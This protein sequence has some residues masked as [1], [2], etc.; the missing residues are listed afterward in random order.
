M[1]IDNSYLSGSSKLSVVAEWGAIQCSLL[2]KAE[3]I[4]CLMDVG[5]SEGCSISV[6]LN[7]VFCSHGTLWGNKAIEFL[8]QHSC[9]FEWICVRFRKRFANFIFKTNAA[10]TLLQPEKNLHHFWPLRR[11]LKR[12]IHCDLLLI[13]EIIWFVPK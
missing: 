9:L 13:E 8:Y 6:K 11:L 4:N 2:S 1:S 5:Q 10:G 12:R 3:R 7:G